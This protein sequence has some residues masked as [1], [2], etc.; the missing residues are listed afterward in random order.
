MGKN[1]GKIHIQIGSS[2][3]N[4]KGQ[5]TVSLNA[6]HMDIGWIATIH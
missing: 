6:K 4:K 3:I 5:E 2:K 1:N